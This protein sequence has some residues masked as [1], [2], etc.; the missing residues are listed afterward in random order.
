M[1]KYVILKKDTLST[2]RSINT[3]VLIDSTR[4][5]RL[6]FLDL[7]SMGFIQSSVEFVKEYWD[8][9]G[10]DIGFPE[11]GHFMQ[12]E[13]SG[14]IYSYNYFDA[15]EI[16]DEWWNKLSKEEQLQKIDHPDDG[17]FIVDFIKEGKISFDSKMHKNNFFEL[18][19]QMNTFYDDKNIHYMVWYED[20]N[21][22]VHLKGFETEEQARAFVANT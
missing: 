2:N 19:E 17:P 3:L 6:D 15:Q 13:P 5:C 10:V 4:G 16:Y 21:D 11:G 20:Q 1:E 18:F 8:G 7:L 14:F 12:D 22:W 9:K